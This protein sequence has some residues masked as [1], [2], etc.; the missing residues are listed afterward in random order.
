VKVEE[1]VMINRPVEEVWKFITDPSKVPTWDTS[2]SEVK[3]TSTGPLS[4]GST[5]EF[6]EK[7]M[8]TTISMRITE[9]E[10][11]RRFSFEHISGPTN[12]SILTY[13]VEII[14]GKMRLTE[15]H[16]LKL[17]GFYKL[18]GLFITSS[19]MRR[20]IAASLGNAK[21]MLESEPKS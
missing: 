12:G 9:Y 1:S 17:S 21:R 11:N 20:E 6:K 13:S 7:M 3:Q 4:V 5:C 14:E 19:R 8:N 15:D 10:P 2:I 16:G 18:L